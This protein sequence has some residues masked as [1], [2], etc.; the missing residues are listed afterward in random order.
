MV[1]KYMSTDERDGIHLYQAAGGEHKSNR[2]M[3]LMHRHHS[4]ERA[5]QAY[6]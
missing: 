1:E 2:K 3:S 4:V 5:Q 6:K